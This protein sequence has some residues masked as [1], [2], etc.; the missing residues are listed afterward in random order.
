MAFKLVTFRQHSSVQGPHHEGALEK[1]NGTSAMDG[2]LR[3][4]WP[5]ANIPGRFIVLHL[6]S[7][8]GADRLLNP[9][10]FLLVSY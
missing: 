3:M 5:S 7:S 1:G 4:S 9:F 2:I 8:F 10:Y 6:D